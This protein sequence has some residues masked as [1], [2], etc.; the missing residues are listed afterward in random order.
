[1]D[2]GAG[3]RQ[4]KDEFR[5]HVFNRQHQSK[6]QE[7]V[8]YEFETRSRVGDPRPCQPAGKSREDARPKLPGSVTSAI[9]QKAAPDDHV[10]ALLLVRVDYLEQILNPMLAV[11][12]K[13][14][15]VFVVVGKGMLHGCPERSGIPAVARMGN[16]GNTSLK[17]DMPGLVL[18]TI[19]NKEQ[20]CSR[21][22]FSQVFYNVVEAFGLIVDRNCNQ[23]FH[24]DSG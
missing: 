7:C 22:H 2:S 9:P 6:R 17:E 10:I 5:M 4:S 18:R 19:V 23:P 1:V 16:K 21:T 11:S 13:E 3:T 12:V 14:D 24:H 20:V 15:N 8:C